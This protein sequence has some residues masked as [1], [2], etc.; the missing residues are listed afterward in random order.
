VISGVEKCIDANTQTSYGINLS[1]SEWH[2]VNDETSTGN[3]NG[4]SN[5]HCTLNWQIVPCE[6]L[7]KQAFSFLKYIAWF[8]V[9]IFILGIV[10]TVFWILMLIDIIKHEEKD[11]TLWIFILVFLNVLWA[12]VYYF[13]AKKHRKEVN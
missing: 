4:I 10:W 1:S 7:Q 6:Q 12:I 3:S 13:T 11:K 2:E 5:N 9:V 8:G